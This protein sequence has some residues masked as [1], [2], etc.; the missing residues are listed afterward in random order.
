MSAT[1]RGPAADLVVLPRDAEGAPVFSAPW[2]AQAFA[3]AVALHDRGVFTWA[4]WA[5]CLGAAVRRP[6]ADADIPYAAW[7]T[8][9]E[10]LVSAKGI[11]GTDGLTARRE[12]LDRAARAT[13]HGAPI[14]LENDPQSR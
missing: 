5:D 11:T 6:E 12:A 8:A 3:M 4:E 7:M 10:T 9:L 14:L 13:P 1:P 2:E